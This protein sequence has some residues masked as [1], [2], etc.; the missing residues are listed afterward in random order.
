MA[1]SVSCGF[2]VLIKQV[3]GST[4]Q[5]GQVHRGG[6]ALFCVCTWCAD[7]DPD[8]EAEEDEAMVEGKERARGE[9]ERDET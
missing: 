8:D 6:V 2:R 5:R 9:G 7:D 3:M 1:R 4:Q